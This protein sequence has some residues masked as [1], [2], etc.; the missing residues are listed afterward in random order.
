M[1]A[2][3]ERDIPTLLLAAG[4][5]ASFMRE[6]ERGIPDLALILHPLDERTSVVFAA[7]REDAGRLA[8]GNQTEPLFN[9]PG[10]DERRAA[11]RLVVSRLWRA[12]AI[13]VA[14][15]VDLD[16]FATP[17]P[18]KVPVAHRQMLSTLLASAWPR[19]LPDL[20]TSSLAL[21]V[22]LESREELEILWLSALSPSAKR[23][24]AHAVRSQAG[25]VWRLAMI[26]CMNPTAGY[27]GLLVTADETTLAGCMKA[28]RDAGV[29]LEDVKPGDDTRVAWQLSQDDGRFVLCCPPASASGA[30]LRPGKPRLT[31]TARA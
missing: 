19:L 2:G 27:R 9:P 3:E 21:P 7:S 11:I 6:L 5:D 4:A 22:R 30:T 23:S 12:V 25:L 10:I 18:D 28:A 1:L 26:T 8:P 13:A 17:V 31:Q 15:E 14:T 29:T 20:A 16:G 24:A